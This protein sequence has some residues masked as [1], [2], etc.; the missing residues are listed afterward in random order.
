MEM[1]WTFI[2]LIA[3]LRGVFME[4]ITTVIPRDEFMLT[5]SLGNGRTVTV[6]LRQKLHTVRFG[7]LRDR[8][9]FAAARTDG[10]AVYWPGGLAI[11][12]GEIMELAGTGEEN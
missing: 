12:I 5:V 7:E 8:Q 1:S 3:N 4:M 9:V 10:K 6:D 2:V 11:A